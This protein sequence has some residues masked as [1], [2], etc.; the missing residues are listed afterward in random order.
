M[1]LIYRAEL[2]RYGC[3]L[4]R[5]MKLRW[6]L[7]ENHLSRGMKLCGKPRENHVAI[8]FSADDCDN[9]ARNARFEDQKRKPATTERESHNSGTR[10]IADHVISTDLCRPR[11]RDGEIANPAK[12]Q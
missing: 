1:G 6:K 8:L 2:K 7:R 12:S 3:R 11:P 10:E 4:R 5:G 9:E